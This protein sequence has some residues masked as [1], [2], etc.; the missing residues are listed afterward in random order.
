MTIRQQSLPGDLWLVTVNGRL[1][2]NITPALEETLNELLN[3][4]HHRLIIDLSEAT[5]INSG[6]LRCLV[7]AW[8]KARQQGGDVYLCG[9]RARV[10]EVFSMVGFDKVFSVY[11]TRREAASAWQ[12]AA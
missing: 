10:A 3:T 2:Q 7:A 9:L 5:Y 8:R 12:E 6:G 11:P 1:D 4:G